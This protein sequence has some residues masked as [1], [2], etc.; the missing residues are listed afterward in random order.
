MKPTNIAEEGPE[1]MFTPKRIGLIVTAYT[2]VGC[3]N[4]PDFHAF[5]EEVLGR[6]V[7]THEFANRELWAELKE[8]MRTEFLAFAT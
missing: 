4:M 7:F 3:C 5:V 2:G 6:P 1:I 8:K